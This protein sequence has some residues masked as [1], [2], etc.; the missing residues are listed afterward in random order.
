M[1]KFSPD[2]LALAQTG[3]RIAYVLDDIKDQLEAEDR[4]V[5]N[6]AYNSIMKGGFTPEQALHTLYQLYANWKLVKR[7]ET[8]VATG[9][10][11]GADVAPH[12]T[13]GAQNG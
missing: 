13:I 3:A 8:R 12:L 6:G 1:A 9:K 10:A 7:L 2:D 11:A 4:A 5:L